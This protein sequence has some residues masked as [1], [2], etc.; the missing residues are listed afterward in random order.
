MAQMV[1]PNVMAAAMLNPN[2]HANPLAVV[3]APA[4]NNRPLIPR[5]KG[6]AGRDYNLRAEMGL[7]NDND[8][9]LR[10]LV[11]YSTT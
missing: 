2:G 1:A 8:L 9:Y 3:P 7:Q 11:S 5:P 10:I 6:T 4:N